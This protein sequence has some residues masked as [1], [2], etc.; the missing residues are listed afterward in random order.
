MKAM[1][2]T[3]VRIFFLDAHCPTPVIA[4]APTIRTP[5]MK[6]NQAELITATGIKHMKK[7]M[8]E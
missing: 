1:P 3:K 2:D 8:I 5:E 7:K 6:K 4:A